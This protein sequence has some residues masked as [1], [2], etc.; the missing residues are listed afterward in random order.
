[1][2]L[3]ARAGYASGPDKALTDGPQWMSPSPRN[4]NSH[5]S[6][7]A[8][9]RLGGERDEGLVPV[10]PAPYRNQS[11]ERAYNSSGHKMSMALIALSPASTCLGHP[12][13]TYC[14]LSKSS[15][16]VTF[17]LYPTYGLVAK[18]IDG[19]RCHLVYGG[20]LRPK[21]GG[22]AARPQFSVHV[23]C[24]QT[25]GWIMMKLG[26]EAGLVPGHIDIRPQQCLL[27]HLF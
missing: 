14:L 12:S 22:T 20:S 24:G 16:S 10:T 26:V 2:V 3:G 15:A 1:M 7:V 18:R 27:S 19:S 9:S 21:N 23:Y 4:T 6:Y 11:I 25:A 13:P 17:S 5:A 8:G